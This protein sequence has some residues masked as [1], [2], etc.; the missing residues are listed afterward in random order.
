M[1]TEDIRG[2]DLPTGKDTV[3]TMGAGDFKTKKIGPLQLI[4]LCGCVNN[5][6]TSRVILNMVNF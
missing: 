6:F 1:Y 5:F 3:C 4:D 2:Q